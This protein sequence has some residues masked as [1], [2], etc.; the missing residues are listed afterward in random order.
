MDGD[1][2]INRDGRKQGIERW[3]DFKPNREIEQGG[4][5]K[6]TGL[7]LFSMNLFLIDILQWDTHTLILVYS[8]VNMNRI[9]SNRK[10]RMYR[11]KGRRKNKKFSVG[12]TAC[13]FV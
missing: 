7:V 6:K 4:T 1:K 8:C 13:Q 10:I 3:K 9:V 5:K 2:E 12:D 11:K